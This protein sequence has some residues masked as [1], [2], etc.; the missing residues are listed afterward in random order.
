MTIHET[1]ES[2]LARI[3]LALAGCKTHAREVPA[4]AEVSRAALEQHQAQIV[5]LLEEHG[6]IRQSLVLMEERINAELRDAARTRARWP[7]AQLPPG[8]RGP[9]ARA[10]V[11]H[12][13]AD[14]PAAAG[15]VVTRDLSGLHRGLRRLAP[16]PPGDP[17]RQVLRERLPAAPRPIGDAGHAST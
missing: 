16:P 3:A 9:P 17:L 12:R 6:R 4:E 13:D 14:G 8:F 11:A 7:D 5:A 10:P 1:T 2:H 15:A